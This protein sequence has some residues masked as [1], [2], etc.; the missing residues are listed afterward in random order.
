MKIVIWTGGALET[1]GAWSMIDGG[2]GG[3][4]TAAARVADHLARR[5]HEVEV[6]GRVRASVV[7]YSAGSCRFVPVESDDVRVDCDVCVSSREPQ[8]IAMQPRCRLSVLWMHDASSG[9]DWYGYLGHYDLVFCLSKWARKAFLAQYPDVRES[10]V[11]VT[12]NGVEPAL[13]LRLGETPDHLRPVLKEGDFRYRFVYSSSP[14]RGLGR[15]LDLWPRIK[16]RVPEAQLGVFYGTG[17]LR[18]WAASSSNPSTRTAMLRSCD[19]VEHRMTELEGEGVYYF[20]RV[21]QADLAQAFLESSLWLYPT[22]FCETFC[23]TALESQAAGCWPV[24][25]RIGALPETCRAGT[26]LAEEPSDP[27][28]DEAF[29]AAVAEAVS[30]RGTR[31]AAQELGEARRHVLTHATWAHV[32]AEWEDLFASKARPA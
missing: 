15:L 3:S 10:R 23:I 25:S 16:K 12:R 29:V 7:S 28:Y 24:T 2:I 19:Y 6:W 11:L 13:F 30:D 27:G 14:D 31:L 26:L 1:W 17:N 32:A 5:G 18:R 20:G 8:A 4:E 22:S 21:G 9:P